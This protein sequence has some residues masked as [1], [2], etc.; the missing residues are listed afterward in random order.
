MLERSRPCPPP[1]NVVNFLREPPQHENDV[2]FE[3]PCDESEQNQAGARDEGENKNGENLQRKEKKQ[4][5]T[6]VDVVSR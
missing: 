1:G 6:F 4:R 2:F 5:E 3:V